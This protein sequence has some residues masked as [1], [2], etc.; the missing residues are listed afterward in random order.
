MHLIFTKN[1]TKGYN[2][3]MRYLQDIVGHPKEF[4]I[5][6]RIKVTEFF[7]KYGLAATR[8]AFGVGRATIYI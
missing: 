6:R 3:C 7:D 8:E 4:E 5:K 2:K 1:F